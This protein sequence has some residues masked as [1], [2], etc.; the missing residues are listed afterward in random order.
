MRDRIFEVF[1]GYQRD[2][3]DL[4]T[5]LSLLY[6]GDRPSAA[7]LNALLRT[8]AGYTRSVEELKRYRSQM[9]DGVARYWPE[10]EREVAGNRL[11]AV[12]AL[13]LEIAH[14]TALGLNDDIVAIHGSLSGE[15]VSD[16]RLRAARI[17]VREA[18]ATLDEALPRTR[19]AI[20][21]L[22]ASI[23]STDGRE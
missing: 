17:S 16:E 7:R 3:A 23:G 10:G 21:E 11:Q 20:E 6:D 2:L 12:L 9:V 15:P 8:I 1:D 19:N 4:V 13:V 18:V 14:P 22:F 5:G